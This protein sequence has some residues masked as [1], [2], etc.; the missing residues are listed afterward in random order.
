[1]LRQRSFNFKTACLVIFLGSCFHTHLTSKYARASIK[2]LYSRMHDGSR[3]D[4]TPMLPQVFAHYHLPNISVR[5][6]SSSGIVTEAASLSLSQ[7]LVLG[8]GIAYFGK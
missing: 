5:T 1:M 8:L 2:F 6:F 7:Y 3:A 4:H